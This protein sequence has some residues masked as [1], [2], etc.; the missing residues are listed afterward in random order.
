M[1]R[2]RQGD[3]RTLAKGAHA[4][5]AEETRTGPNKARV[6]QVGASGTPPA[7]TPGS[8]AETPLEAVVEQAQ[9]VETA[10]LGDVG[11]LGRGIPQK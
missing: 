2:L 11:N 7:P 1:R 9:M 8:F 10:R 3:F 4:H 5:A 6:T